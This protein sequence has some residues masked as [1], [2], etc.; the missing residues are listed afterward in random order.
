MPRVEY[1][2]IILSRARWQLKSSI[3]NDI[4]DLKSAEEIADFKKKI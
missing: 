1:K 2:H 3:Y 4:K